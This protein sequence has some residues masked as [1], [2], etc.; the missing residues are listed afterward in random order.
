M[1]TGAERQGTKGYFVERTILITTPKNSRSYKED[2]FGPVLVVR[3]FKPEQEVIKLANE[4]EYGL[5]A[6]SML[7]I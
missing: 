6:T 1:L 5:A 4:S 7:L 3:A 2:I